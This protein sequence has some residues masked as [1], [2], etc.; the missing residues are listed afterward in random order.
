MQTVIQDLQRDPCEGRG[1]LRGLASFTDTKTSLDASCV[2]RQLRDLPHQHLHRVVQ[3]CYRTISAVVMP[4]PRALMAASSCTTAQVTHNRATVK[5][6]GQAQHQGL[7]T[8]H[9]TLCKEHRITNS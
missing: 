6:V 1:Y 5:G 7:L 2:T 4:K 9:E 3:R 8:L